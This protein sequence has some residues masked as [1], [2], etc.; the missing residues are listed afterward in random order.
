[1]LEI[2]CNYSSRVLKVLFLAYFIL[3]GITVCGHFAKSFIIVF[4]K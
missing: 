1:M 3:L 2:T 4:C